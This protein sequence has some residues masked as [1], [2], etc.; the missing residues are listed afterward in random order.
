M[1]WGHLTTVSTRD[2]DRCDRGADDCSGDVAGEDDDGD[3]GDAGCGDDG[4][5]DDG[6]GDDD[7]DEYGCDDVNLLVYQYVENVHGDS[8][9]LSMIRTTNM[10]AGYRVFM[11]CSDMLP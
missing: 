3:S 8:R 2:Y 6:D 10:Y 1:R 5:G 7:D 11:P 4:T 9:Y